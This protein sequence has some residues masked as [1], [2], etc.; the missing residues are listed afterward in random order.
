MEKKKVENK[1]FDK[2]YLL[3]IHE[4][5]STLPGELEELKILL[6]KFDD[7]C[8]KEMDNNGE[9]PGKEFRNE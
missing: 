4:D 1:L 3:G 9:Q 5:V 6:Q 2:R 7:R 8:R